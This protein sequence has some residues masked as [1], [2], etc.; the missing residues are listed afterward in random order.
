MTAA[1]SEGTTAGAVA[2]SS[3]G[4]V[5]LAV[6]LLVLLVLL[7]SMTVGGRVGHLDPEAFDPTGSHAVK[8]LLEDRGVRVQVVTDLPATR[9]RASSTTTVLVAQAELL[10]DEE[11]QLLSALPSRL[12]V[13]VGG[14][15]V[16][17]ALVPSARTGEPVELR[18]RRPGCELPEARRAGQVHLGG[19]TF[20]PVAG[21]VRCY[22]GTLLALPGSRRVLVG[23]AEL[24]TNDLLDDEGNAALALGLLGQEPTLLWLLPDPFR[25]EIG[26]KPVQDLYELLPAWVGWVALQLALATVLLALWRARRLGRVVPE[27]LPVVVP[28]AE[29]TEGRGR[30][31]RATGARGSAAEALRQAA[32]ERLA[33]RLSAGAGATPEALVAL[34]AARTGRSATDVHALLYGPQPADDAALVRLAGDL[35]ALT[36][37]AVRPNP[38]HPNPSPPNPDP[39]VRAE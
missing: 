22:D 11:L 33:L 27:P 28:A 36:D 13:N 7:A 12:V 4:P 18:P 35:D 39:E 1:T 37:D 23:A 16:A 14:Q 19:P 29:T 5:A 30:L 20:E 21:G 15:R 3:R 17:S 8:A 6:T 24:L 9:A 31:Y 32:R 10:S 26:T 34:V 2:R 38:S 25:D